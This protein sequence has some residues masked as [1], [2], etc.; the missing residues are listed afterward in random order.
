MSANG[1]ML[2]RQSD[3]EIGKFADNF[4]DLSNIS[5]QSVFNRELRHVRIRGKVA[6]YALPDY[7]N[8]VESQ[9]VD[10]ETEGVDFSRCDLKDNTLINCR[11]GKTIFVGMGFVLNTVSTSTFEGCRFFDTVIQNCE[12][13]DV[14]F[15]HCDFT[16][17]VIKDCVFTRCSFKYCQTSNKLFEM[18]HLT[19][20]YFDQTPL[21]L[22]TITEN[23]GLRAEQINAPIR[24]DRV[25]HPHEELDRTAISSRLATETHPLARLSL[26]YY[27]TGNLLDGSEHL[28]AALDVGY[29]IRT[30]ST[31]GSFSVILTRL[32]EF[33]LNLHECGEL[34]YLPLAQLQ[35]ITGKLASAVPSDSRM[36]QAEFAVYGA[37]L[38]LTRRIDEFVTSVGRF[39]ETRRRKWVFLVEGKHSREF[40]RTKLSELFEIGSPR[41]LSLVPHNS[42][43][44]MALSFPSSATAG[45]FLALFFATRTRIEIRKLVE[46][47]EVTSSK[48]GRSKV[49]RPQ[50]AQFT[51][52]AAKSTESKALVHFTTRVSS[53]LTADFQFSVSTRCVGRIRRIMLSWLK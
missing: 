48:R 11:F 16:S 2:V 17:L 1:K 50:I 46:V 38:S 28:D 45:G 31:I 32:C 14:E 36:R 9:L 40:Y 49:G 41:I 33:L 24:S 42:P 35:T 7:C 25:D 43:W 3:A 8:F 47:L 37:H 6:N 22:Q 44:E 21:Q 29:W 19:G 30:Q 27:L 12:F 18:C 52:G 20:C 4:F 53:T 39:T 23:F 13:Y 34:A 5:P 26:D 51:F 10:F 15:K